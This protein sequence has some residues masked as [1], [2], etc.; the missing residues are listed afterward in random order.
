MGAL[1]IESVAARTL[2]VGDNIRLERDR[3][4]RIASIAFE[5][6]RLIV[7]GRHNKTATALKIRTYDGTEF[8]IHPGSIVGLK[9]DRANSRQ[10]LYAMIAVIC[11]WFGVSYTSSTKDQ[12]LTDGVGPVIL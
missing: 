10:W 5:E 9:R 3:F 11:G 8:L 1:E 7:G 4:E 12:I 2:K 6:G